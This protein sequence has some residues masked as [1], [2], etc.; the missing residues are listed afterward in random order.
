[1]IFFKKK[2]Q[3][4]DI[5]NERILD[6]KVF[7]VNEL[8]LRILSFLPN[9]YCQ[10][11][12]FLSKTVHSQIQ[13]HC[14]DQ[15]ICF[16]LTFFELCLACCRE[17]ELNILRWTKEWGHNLLKLMHYHELAEKASKG[18]HCQILEYLQENKMLNISEYCFIVAPNLEVLKWLYSHPNDLI[19]SDTYKTILSLILIN[20]DLEAFKWYRNN[21]SVT[22]STKLLEHALYSGN[23]NLCEE[24][25]TNYGGVL[26]KKAPFYII[27][28]GHLHLITY[29]EQKYRTEFAN[30]N[31]LLIAMQ[32]ARMEIV[33]YLSN[34]NPYII[35]ETISGY[36]ESIWSWT[37]FNPDMRHAD[38][39]TWCF[40]KGLVANV[41]KTTSTAT[42]SCVLNLHFW[43]LF[44][45]YKIKI[46]EDLLITKILNSRDY[47]KIKW[48]IQNLKFR[49][50]DLNI[51][52]EMATTQ[53]RPE[54]VY[55]LKEKGYLEKGMVI[56]IDS[57][58]TG[59]V[60][61]E[62]IQFLVL[63]NHIEWQESFFTKAGKLG[64]LDIIRWGFK[65]GYKIPLSTFTN[66][67]SMDF[68]HILKWAYAN[69]VLSNTKECLKEAQNYAR[70]MGSRYH[71][72]V[73]D[74]LET[75]E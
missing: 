34:K 32:H 21:F 68:L 16:D 3:S 66:A 42:D 14:L 13:T 49:Q 6:N 19:S 53:N 35:N 27:S 4:M 12:K 38:V 11:L 70:V 15:D 10:I 58:M 71:S 72:K 25:M 57:Y 56:H 5:E 31:N 45:K 18:G 73:K 26:T 60:G 54:I 39:L 51:V 7:E 30:R 64:R 41:F 46:D 43:S 48:Y 62:M 17:G 2:T 40:D 33:E 47:I 24:I 23:I 61:L 74:W 69:N 44:Q 63:N 9:H 8:F 55:A 28:C 22:K 65:C 52:V 36:N 20:G 29:F 1:M 59:C 67:A 37:E 50:A 75:L